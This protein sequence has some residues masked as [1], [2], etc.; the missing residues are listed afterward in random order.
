MRICCVEDQTPTLEILELVISQQV[1]DASTHMFSDAPEALEFLNE[2]KVDLIISDLE[3]FGSKKLEIVKFANSKNIPCIVY[4]AHCEQGFIN[5]VFDAGATAFVSK[6]E[7]I[8]TIRE[9]IA[10]WEDLSAKNGSHEPL[11]NKESF[12]KLDLNER[13]TK[14]LKLLIQGA[15]REEMGR[16]LHLSP[17]TINSYIRDLCYKHECKKEELIH[18]F[19]TWETIK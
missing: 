13:D 1:P 2:N 19:L 14:I 18:R 9:A 8:D 4:S 5:A 11:E 16:K 3:F 15:T 6:F 7:S 12:K 10:S 17:N